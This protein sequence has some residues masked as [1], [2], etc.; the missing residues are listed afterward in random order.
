MIQEQE[1]LSKID[2]FMLEELQI[3]P[4]T[5]SIQTLRQEVNKLSDELNR[6]RDDP[7]ISKMSSVKSIE[8]GL[9]DIIIKM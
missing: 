2:K 4:E 3:I 8:Q 1:F 5:P 6:L 7:Y 9:E